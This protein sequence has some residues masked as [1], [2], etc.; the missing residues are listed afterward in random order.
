M[1]GTPTLGS[2]ALGATLAEAGKLKEVH[3]L[4]FNAKDFLLDG[5]R[6]VNSR[7]DKCQLTVLSNQFEL[8]SCHLDESSQVLYGADPLK[9]I[10][11]WNSRTPYFYENFPAYAPVKNNDG[12]ITIKG[13]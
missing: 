6:L 4:W 12:T 7:F 9:I 13:I 10:K 2:N 8:I 11:L 1:L 5:Y 3:G